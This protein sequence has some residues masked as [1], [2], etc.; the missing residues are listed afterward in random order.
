[1]R[2]FISPRKQGDQN[3]I[4]R[5]AVVANNFEIKPSMIQMIQNSQFNDLSHEDPIGHITRFLEYCSSFK[6]NGVQPDAIR[7]ILLPFFTY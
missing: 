6:M 5:P 1:M 4:M 2:D 3:P 7:L